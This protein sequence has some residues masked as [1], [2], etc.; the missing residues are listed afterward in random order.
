MD[1]SALPQLRPQTEAASHVLQRDAWKIRTFRLMSAANGEL[2]HHH[3]LIYSRDRVPTRMRLR[4][5]CKRLNKH[6][7]LDRERIHCEWLRE[8][9]QHRDLVYPQHDRRTGGRR[10]DS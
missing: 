6:L 1:V 7:L 3:S 8:H 5:L 9:C 4:S 2:A 10:S